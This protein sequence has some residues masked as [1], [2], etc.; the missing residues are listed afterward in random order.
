MNTFGRIFKVSIFGESHGTAVGVCIDGCPP[1]I[2]LEIKDFEIDLKR[3]QGG[4]Q[5]GSTPRKEDDVP[6]ILSGLF[7]GYTTGAPLTIIINNKNVRSSDYS[8]LKKTP[9]P[10]HADFVSSIK[11]KGY[12]DYRGGGHFSGRLTACLVMAGVVAKKIISQKFTLVKFQAKV[13]EVGG[14][15]NIENAVSEAINKNDSVGSKIECNISGLP[16]GL[17]EPFFDSVESLISHAVFSIPAIKGIEFGSGFSSASMYGSMH[18]DAIINKEGVTSTNNAGG[19]NG[20]LTNG[21]DIIFRVAVK[22]ASSTPHK[23]K[24]INLESGM[25]EEIQVGGR[26]DLVI[27]LRVPPVLECVSA[28]VIAD[29]LLLE[30]LL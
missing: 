16:A 7:N 14:N 2:P 3:R 25:I 21:N 17:G 5:K 12:Q 27:G 20:G 23:Q 11:Y 10:G 29:L 13:M 26:H 1:G 15:T 18:N 4:L 30:S 24:S 19:I 22:P 9:R 28:M 6:E 8:E